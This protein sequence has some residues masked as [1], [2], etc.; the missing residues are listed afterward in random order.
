[1][2]ELCEAT[3]RQAR[4]ERADFL[5][6]RT[7][8]GT[9][10]EHRSLP[11]GSLKDFH[12][13]DLDILRGY[14]F[15]IGRGDTR[16]FI[17]SVTPDGFEHYERLMASRQS[18][19]DNVEATVRRMLDSSWFASEYGNA[20]AC[21]RK[22]SDLFWSDHADED[23]SAIGHHC[24]E[25]MQLFGVVFALRCGAEPE[26]P[27]HTIANV[28]GGLGKLNLP[29]S[30]KKMLDALLT[31]WVTVTK[32]VQRQEHGASKEGEQLTIEDGR[33]AVFH[34]AVTM[35]ELATAQMVYG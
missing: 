28:R 32:I 27:D 17:F 12:W 20:A 2:I 22:A 29:E 26:S 18:A 6:T 16:S 25:A 4:T 5:A 33:L 30:R 15:L 23:A 9:S 24:R 21:W 31:Y 1:M 19:L 35:Y 7:M 10:I 8:G 14:G 13:T 11:D 34:T 3:R